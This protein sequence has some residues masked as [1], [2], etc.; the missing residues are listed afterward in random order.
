VPVYSTAAGLS[1][2]IQL[3]GRPSAEADLLT[4]SAQL[5]DHLRLPRHSY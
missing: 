2:S 4:V 5:E 1:M 3:I